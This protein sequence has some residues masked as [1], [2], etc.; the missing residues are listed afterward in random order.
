M[1]NL[2]KQERSVRPLS[3]QAYKE[4][5]KVT[6][7]ATK[8]VSH[9]PKITSMDQILDNKCPKLNTHPLSFEYVSLS[10]QKWIPIIYNVTNSLTKKQAD[11]SAEMIVEKWPTLRFNE[12]AFVIK[13]SWSDRNFNRIDVSVVMQWFQDYAKASGELIAHH[14]ATRHKQLSQPIPDHKSTPPK[15]IEARERLE[16]KVTEN[17]IAKSKAKTQKYNQDRADFE[18]N[19]QLINQSLLLATILEYFKLK[20][21][22]NPPPL[23]GVSSPGSLT[24]TNGI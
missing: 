23:E 20:N 13:E 19:K 21:A 6:D 18:H 14:V 16:Q 22:K 9:Y 7:L 1:T 12:I 24:P 4:I 15:Y 2:A 10:L 8:V 5:T 17:R 11:I 3:L